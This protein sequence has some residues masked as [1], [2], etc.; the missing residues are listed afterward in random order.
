MLYVAQ[1]ARPSD[2]LTVEADVGEQDL[3]L[4]LDIHHVGSVD[5][6]LGEAVVIHEG[7]QRAE[8][9]EVSRVELGGNAHRCTPVQAKAKSGMG[10]AEIVPAVSRSKRR[11]T[12]SIHDLFLTGPVAAGRIEP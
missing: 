5:H 1:L 6:D 11:A 2:L 12:G 8:S 9:L 4:A 7:T 10:S 3:A